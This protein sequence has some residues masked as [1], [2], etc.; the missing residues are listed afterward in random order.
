MWVRVMQ[1]TATSV[2]FAC[3]SFAIHV[4]SWWSMSIPHII[5][6]GFMAVA[7]K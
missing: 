1:V 5:D 7:Q 6:R 4:M 2:F 3:D